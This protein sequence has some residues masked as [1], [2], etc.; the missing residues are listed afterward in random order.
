MTRDEGA[1][2]SVE[3]EDSGR[4]AWW[5]RIWARTE[6][7]MVTRAGARL[8][9]GEGTRLA[10]GNERTVYRYSRSGSG[11][12]WEVEIEGGHGVV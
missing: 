8:R 9:A 2:S 1:S 12:G 3:E 5:S 11:G 6:G 10:E 4:R 7:W